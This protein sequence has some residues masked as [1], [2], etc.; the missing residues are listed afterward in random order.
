MLAI[1][2]DY[3]ISKI[4]RM[5]KK[6][7]SLTHNGLSESSSMNDAKLVAKIMMKKNLYACRD[8]DIM[9]QMIV[10]QNQRE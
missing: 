4:K 3:P 1:I 2:A 7:S 8:I 9:F 10:S 6:R 5:T